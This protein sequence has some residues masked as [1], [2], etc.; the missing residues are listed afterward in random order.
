MLRKLLQPFY[1]A[2][3]VIIFVATLFTVLPFYILLSIP[4]NKHFRKIMWLLSKYWA[5]VWLWLA[6]MPV[7]VYG[8]MPGQRKYVVVANHVSYL[9]AIVIFDMFPWYFRPLGKKELSKAPLFGFI[10][11]QMAL[12]VDRSNPYSRAKSMRLMW[13]ALRH[14]CNIFIYPEGT[15]NETADP[16]KS[17]YDGAFRLAINAG[18]PILPILFPDTKARWHYS[19]WWKIWPGKNRAFIMEPISAEGLGVE[20]VATLREKVKAIMSARMKELMP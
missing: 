13:R 15:F 18:V 2:Y 8:S 5:R 17:F 19:K 11:K 16:M 6:G 9:D 3:V 4:H 20:D 12:M 1:T 10:Y 7:K 14:E